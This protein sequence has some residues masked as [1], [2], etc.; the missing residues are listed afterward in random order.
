MKKIQLFKTCSILAVCL[1]SVLLLS[2]AT[3]VH[4]NNKQN[5]KQ[6]DLPVVELKQFTHVVDQ[7]KKYYVD[8]VED[9]KLFEEAVRGMLAG[10]DPHSAYLDKDMMQDLKVSTSGKFGGLGIEVTME[11]GFVKVVSP[12]DDTPAS[13]AG[14]Q[15]GD[16]IIRID[17]TPVK[18]MS[19]NDAVT[20][21]RGPKGA[22]IS[23][24]IIRDGAD[25]PIVVELARDTIKVHSAR[26]EILEPGYGY[27]RISTF[28]AQTGDDV[29]KALHK[30][31]QENKGDLSGL[32]LDLRNNPGGVLEAAVDV[33]DIFLDSKKIGYDRLV[34]Y[35][36][37]RMS[38]SKLREH[39]RT[40]DVIDGAPMVVLVNGGSASA[41]EI[42]AGALQDH[43]RAIIMGGQTFGKGS[44][45]TVIPLQ[46]DNGLKLTTALYYTPSGRSI[47]AEGIKPDIT[48]QNYVLSHGDNTFVSMAVR[49]SNLSNHINNGKGD[50]E[51]EVEIKVEEPQDYAIIEALNL[52]KGLHILSAQAQSR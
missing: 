11:D 22:K 28:Q 21:M 27:L 10:L 37:G 43:A 5:N 41:S 39:A 1:S 34:V 2:I 46:E 35:T 33:S 49:E 6:K 30:L 32:I 36:E 44:V 29:K 45:Q 3:Q 18:G 9:E 26:A 47:Q 25:A 16:L 19:L 50:G 20:R 17:D 13:R 14:I 51:E 15:P 8:E 52:L 48:L 31:K 12:I 7:I 38:S 24:T 40:G 23:L 42:V 4:A